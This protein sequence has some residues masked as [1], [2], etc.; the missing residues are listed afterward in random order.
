MASFNISGPDLDL[1]LTL[2]VLQQ[3][4][5][6]PTY[7]NPPITISAI[8]AA[9]SNWQQISVADINPF[10]QGKR[11]STMTGLIDTS[12]QYTEI[13]PIARRKSNSINGYK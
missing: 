6:T 1:N 2:N 3:P 4:G 10:R 11:F 8:L 7:F 13:S 5:Q 9:M 12:L